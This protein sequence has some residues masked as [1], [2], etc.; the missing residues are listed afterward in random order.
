MGVETQVS[1]PLVS[2]AIFGRLLLVRA[3]G[4]A[5]RALVIFWPSQLG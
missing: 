3:V 4:E 1:R 5:L 2:K